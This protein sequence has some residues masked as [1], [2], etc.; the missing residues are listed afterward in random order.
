MLFVGH[1]FAV[2]YI[3]F[4]VVQVYKLIVDGTHGYPVR[5]PAAVQL[6]GADQNDRNPSAV[7]GLGYGFQCERIMMQLNAGLADI[8]QNPS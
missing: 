2:F 7:K 8:L 4:R 5:H 1:S 6:P 3:D